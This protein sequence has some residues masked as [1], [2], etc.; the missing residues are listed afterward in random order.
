[1][2]ERGPEL[3][4]AS[5]PQGNAS[6]KHLLMYGGKRM[7]APIHREWTRVMDLRTSSCRL[8]IAYLRNLIGEN[9]LVPRAP[10]QDPLVLID[11]E[12]PDWC[13]SFSTSGKPKKIQFI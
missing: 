5:R 3:G 9:L 4:L 7:A 8:R 2:L 13:C 12:K 1:M 10:E 11:L 6:R